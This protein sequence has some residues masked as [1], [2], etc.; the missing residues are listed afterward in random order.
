MAARDGATATGAAQQRRGLAGGLGAYLLWGFFPLFWP[1]LDRAAATEILAQRIVWSLA[2]ALLASLVLRRRFWQGLH[3]FRDWGAMLGAGLLITVNWG[4]YIW[5]VNNGHVLDAALGYYINPILS[6]LIGV[7]FLRERLSPLQWVAVGIAALA[8]VVLTV[9]L[10]G[11]PWV[12]LVLAT[13]FGLYGLFKKRVRVDALSGMVAEGLGISVLALAY[14][15]WL[16]ATGADTFTR[17]GA[18]HAGLLVLSGLITLVP[19]LLFADA[20]QRLPLS[21]MGLL[22]YIAPTTQFL[23]GW[24]L[25]GEEMEPGR[26]AGFLLVW[27]SLVL[28]SGEALSRWRPLDRARSRALA[29]RQDRTP[30]S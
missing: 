7:L 24:L 4:T 18:G 8:V 13:S 30:T 3:G 12:A 23:I 11:L 14:I 22:Q 5:A 26:W 28:I 21:M 17:L 25:L 16:T 15:G 1:L 20:A 6:I 2:F 10:G 19:L 29:A 9:Q 27:L